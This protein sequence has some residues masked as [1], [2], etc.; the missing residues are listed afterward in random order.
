MIQSDDASRSGCCRLQRLM[1]NETY[2]F[3]RWEEQMTVT[4][5][6][7]GCAAHIPP[8]LHKCVFHSSRDDTENCDG[9]GIDCDHC[10]G[11]FVGD[12]NYTTVNTYTD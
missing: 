3:G 1:L 6:Q 12:S 5:C 8:I 2:T 10:N 4:D 7:A 11:E 9:D